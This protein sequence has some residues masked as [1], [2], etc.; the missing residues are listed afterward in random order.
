LLPHLYDD[1]VKARHNPAQTAGGLST[2]DAKAA[3]WFALAAELAAEDA[4]TTTATT[5]EVDV[6]V[7]TLDG[8]RS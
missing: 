8:G 2:R 1:A 7:L 6:E 5:A 4:D 3:G